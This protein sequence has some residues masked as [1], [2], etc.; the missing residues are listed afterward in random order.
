[1]SQSQS[2]NYMSQEVVEGSKT[3]I[4]RVVNIRFKIIFFSFSFL[5]LFQFIFNFGKLRLGFSVILYVTVTHQSHKLHITI[6]NSR[7][8]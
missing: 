7:K 3:I 8:F 6:K 5:F 4:V 2:H 1:M